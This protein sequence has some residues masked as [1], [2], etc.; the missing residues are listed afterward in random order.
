[1]IT[2]IARYLVAVPLCERGRQLKIKIQIYKFGQMK[3]CYG[4]LRLAESRFDIYFWLCLS[5]QILLSSLL[6]AFVQTHDGS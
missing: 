5:I 4:V 2:A 1:M 6:L 3:K